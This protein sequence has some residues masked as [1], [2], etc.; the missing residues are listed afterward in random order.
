ML[1]VAQRQKLVAC[2]TWHLTCFWYPDAL[3]M[4]AQMR[5]LVG[6]TKEEIEEND[7]ILIAYIDGKKC[8]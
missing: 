2:G 4:Y 3:I 6:L 1:T 8:G 5:G 7:V